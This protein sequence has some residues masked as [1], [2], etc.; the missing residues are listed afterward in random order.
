MIRTRGRGATYGEL[1]YAEEA[2]RPPGVDILAY[3]QRPIPVPDGSHTPF[4]SAVTE[5][6]HDADSII[7][8]FHATCRHQI[9]R[10]ERNDGL[11][12]EF[13]TEPRSRI[14]EFRAFFDAFA[15]RKGI[16]RSDHQWLRAACNARQLILSLASRG[17]EIL[18]WHAYVISGTTVGFQYSCS[19]FRDREPEYRALVGR[20]NRWLHW[21][22]MLRLKDLGMRRYDW[23]GLFEDESAAD[24]ASINYFKR[25]FGPREER[26]Y[27]CMVPVTI[28]GRMWLPMREA[29]NRRRSISPPSWFGSKA[30]P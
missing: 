6:G 17:G 11:D 14:D 5:L 28:R 30:T 4:L 15:A 29:W 3:R 25:N 2:P 22:D 12:M 9:R 23:G 10:A 19:W 18:V 16:G 20:A 21:Q 7:A 8:R 1:W 27:N 26:S 24:R 13:I